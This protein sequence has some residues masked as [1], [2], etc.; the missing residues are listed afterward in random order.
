[1][2]I[3]EAKAKF[4]QTW[5]AMGADW[6]VNRT[7]AQIHALLLVS[8]GALSADEVMEDLKIS[9]GNANMNLR[10]L[11]EWGLVF[12]ELRPG[13]R[14]EYFYA[15]KDIW[16]VVTQIIIHRKKKELEPVLRALDEISS[17]E[18]EPADIEEFTRIVHDI[19]VFSQKADK[20][21]DRLSSFN[22]ETILNF[23]KMIH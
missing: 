21:L 1:M 12:K 17:V 4:L 20:A 15:E 19:R 16:K 3:Q 2:E 9:R 7:M 13:D 10:K 14:R 8:P 11:I 18:G 22:A 6:G 23:L 5:G